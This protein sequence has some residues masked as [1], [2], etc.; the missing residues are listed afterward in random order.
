MAIKLTRTSDGDDR[1]FFAATM[2]KLSIF[3]PMLALVGSVFYLVT[4]FEDIVHSLR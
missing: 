3:I 1:N 4:H 2:D